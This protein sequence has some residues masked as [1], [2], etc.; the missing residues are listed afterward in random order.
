MLLLRAE[1]L[2]RI[3]D[4]AEAAYPEE[5]CGLLVGL[6]RPNG[7][8]EVTEVAVSANVAPAPRTRRFEVD[9]KLRFALHKRAGPTQVIGV[10]HSHPDEPARPSVTDL[11]MAWEPALAWLITSVVAGQAVM[12]T[13]HALAA[14]GGAFEGLDIEVIEHARRLDALGSGD[15]K[16]GFS[17]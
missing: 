13:A 12:T 4:Q 3:V 8:L 6:R 1:H 15:R 14:H 2:K 16:H 11:A 17:Q 9:P 7:D 5:A 10:Y